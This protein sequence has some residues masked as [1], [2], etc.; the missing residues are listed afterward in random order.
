MGLSKEQIQEFKRLYLKRFGEE[1][2]DQEAYEKGMRLATLMLVIYK[3][4]KIKCLEK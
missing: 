1:I 2:A 4:I 3:S